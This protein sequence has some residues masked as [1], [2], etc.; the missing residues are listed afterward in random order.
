LKKEPRFAGGLKLGGMVVAGVEVELV[1]EAVLELVCESLR[2]KLLE[3]W[4]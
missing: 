2:E 3:R 4:I 1:F